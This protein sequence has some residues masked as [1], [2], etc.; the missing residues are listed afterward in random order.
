MSICTLIDLFER[1][2]DKF[3][4]S[5]SLLEKFNYEFGAGLSSLGV[6]SKDHIILLSEGRNDW[7]ITELDL[8]N[9]GAVSIECLN[10]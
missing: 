7:I 6:G 2:V 9:S 3:I 4:D 5:T 10:N 1:S 8:L